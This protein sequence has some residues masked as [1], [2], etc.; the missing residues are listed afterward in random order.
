[1]R[2]ASLGS[3]SKGNA[4]IVECGNTRVMIDCGFSAKETERRL[5]RLNLEPQQLDAMLVTHEHADHSSGV[6]VVSRKFNIPVYLTHGTQSTGRC[7]KLPFAHYFN[8]GVEFDLGDIAVSTVA[9]PHDAREPCQYILSGRGKTLGV[10]TDLGSITPFIVD[11]YGGCDAMVLEFN[12]DSKMLAEGDYPAAL[13]RR[14]GSDWGHLNNGQSAE[15]LER[16]NTDNFQHLVVAHVSD[17][18]NCSTIAMAA[19]EEVCDLDGRTLLADQD[20]G[21]NWLELN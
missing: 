1:M 3:G 19:L 11:S 16:V 10:L 5:A 4:T 9:V 20:L 18:N 13:K 21:F 14:V 2:F 8:C 15:F 17:K 12:H 7:G 6:S